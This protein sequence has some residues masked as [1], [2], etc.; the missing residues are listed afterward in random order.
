MSVAKLEQ[1]VILPETPATMAIDF[2]L[3]DQLL[4]EGERS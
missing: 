4:T 3:I 1:Y 2:K